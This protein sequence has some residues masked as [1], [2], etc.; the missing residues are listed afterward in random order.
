MVD[1]APRAAVGAAAASARGRRA[2]ESGS[3]GGRL[4][5]DGFPAVLLL[6]VAPFAALFLGALGHPAG[7]LDSDG[8]VR[9]RTEAWRD[10]A[11]VAARSAGVE[12]DLLLALVATESSGRPRARSAAGAVGLAQLMPATARGEAVRLGMAGA[13]DLDLFDPDLNLRLGAAY[14]ADRLAD[15]GGDVPLALAAYHS[16]PAAPA[17]WRR[18]DPAAAG[19]D[20]VRSRASARTRAYVERVM[21][22]REWFREGDGTR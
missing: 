18:E 19:L 12:P 3:E 17:S 13:G 10:R 16:G 8:E 4:R 9:A 20:L 1:G 21:A 2:G 15:L 14:L 5:R 7:I 6:V 22:R 11:T